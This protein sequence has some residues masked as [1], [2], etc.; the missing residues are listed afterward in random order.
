V[1]TLRQT[2][3]TALLDA[4]ETL[5][6]LVAVGT[7]RGAHADPGNL[8]ESENAMSDEISSNL[9][10]AGWI[11]S[12]LGFLVWAMFCAIQSSDSTNHKKWW[13]FLWLKFLAIPVLAWLWF[14][15]VGYGVYRVAR[16]STNGIDYCERPPTVIPAKPEVIDLNLKEKP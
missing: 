7:Y 14:P 15:W 9:Q 10:N 16:W 5:A 13:F 6:A 12:G 2:G 1:G 8:T 11:I 3:E 4:G